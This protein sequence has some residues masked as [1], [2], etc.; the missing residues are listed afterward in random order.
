MNPAMDRTWGCTPIL[1]NI[2]PTGAMI[3]RYLALF[4][5]LIKTI[6]AIDLPGFQRDRLAPTFFTIR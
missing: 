3:L 2:S 5:S 1:A 4:F 6:P